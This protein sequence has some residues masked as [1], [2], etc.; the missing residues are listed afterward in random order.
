MHIV[1]G[2]V[3]A[4]GALTLVKL[5]HASWLCDREHPSPPS[6]PVGPLVPPEQAQRPAQAVPYSTFPGDANNPLTQPGLLKPQP[7][8][9]ADAFIPLPP[10]KM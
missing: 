5:F 4:L 9:S 7:P 1:T 8:T 10:V 6:P 3:L 2:I